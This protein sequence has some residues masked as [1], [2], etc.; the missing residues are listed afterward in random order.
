MIFKASI[1]SILR[2]IIICDDVLSFVPARAGL[3]CFNVL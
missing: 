2:L 1:S 3:A